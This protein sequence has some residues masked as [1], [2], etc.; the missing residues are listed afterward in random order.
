MYVLESISSRILTYFGSILCLWNHAMSLRC[1][2]LTCKLTEDFYYNNSWH[3]GNDIPKI[4][5]IGMRISKPIILYIWSW[6]VYQVCSYTW[7]IRMKFVSN[8]YTY[9]ISTYIWIDV[10]TFLSIL[11]MLR[12]TVKFRRKHIYNII[13]V[14][15]DVIR[16]YICIKFCIAFFYSYS[17]M[18]DI[19]LRVCQHLH[20]RSLP[21]SV[22]KWV[23]SEV[24]ICVWL[25]HKI[26]CDYVPGSDRYMCTVVVLLFHLEMSLYSCKYKSQWRLFSDR[27]ESTVMIP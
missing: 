15:I 21:L 22:V 1:F 25:M 16:V 23:L 3:F 18:S 10:T 2:A 27:G 24:T 14:I 6:C 8:S 26:L 13:T 12:I 4:E 11:A 7:G 17:M 5:R 19:L 9:I 20:L